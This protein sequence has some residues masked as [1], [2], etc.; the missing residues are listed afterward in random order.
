MSSSMASPFGAAASVPEDISLGWN[1]SVATASKARVRCAVSPAS[2][3]AVKAATR[4][5]GGRT[6]SISSVRDQ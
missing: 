5:G 3:S 4:A 6:L 2:M 1:L